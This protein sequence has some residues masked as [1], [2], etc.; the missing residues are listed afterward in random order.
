MCR[1]P[2]PPPPVQKFWTHA[3]VARHFAPPPKQTPW[4]R[5]AD[6][7]VWVHVILQVILDPQKIDKKGRV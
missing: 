2:S 4:R 1:S 7:G 6:P 5:P 3:A